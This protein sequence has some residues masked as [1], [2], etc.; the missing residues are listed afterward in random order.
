MCGGHY[1]FDKNKSLNLDIVAGESGG[2][3]DIGFSKRF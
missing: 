2:S 1:G 3:V